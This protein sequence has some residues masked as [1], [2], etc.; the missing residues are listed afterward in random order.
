MR[1]GADQVGGGAPPDPNGSDADR[2]GLSTGAEAAA[3]Y[4]VVEAEDMDAA[5]KL[6][7]HCP[8]AT[9][10]RISPTMQMNG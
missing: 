5:V 6:L 9:S 3:G 8:I 2:S 7:E 10:V 4:T 1:D